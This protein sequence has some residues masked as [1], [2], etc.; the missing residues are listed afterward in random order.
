MT[1]PFPPLSS[2]SYFPLLSLPYLTAA[3]GY[4]PRKKFMLELKMLVGEF[5]IILDININT[6]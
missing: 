1:Q 5:E 3:R 6:F 2:S 4:H